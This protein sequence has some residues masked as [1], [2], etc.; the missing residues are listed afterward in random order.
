MPSDYK[1]CGYCGE[2]FPK[3]AFCPACGA[4]VEENQK[5]CK[6]CGTVLK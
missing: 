4:P 5:F 1:F 3:Q 6:E 2:P